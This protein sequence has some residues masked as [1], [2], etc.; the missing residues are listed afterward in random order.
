VIEATYRVRRDRIDG[1]GAVTLRHDSTLL[2]IKVGRRHAGT[3]VLLLVA[4]LDVRV[5][6]EDGELLRELTI[7]PTRSYKGLGSDEV[8]G[9]RETGVNDVGRHHISGVFSE[10]A[11]QGIQHSI[12]RAPTG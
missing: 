4:G 8:Q 10:L 9:C 12:R 11:G 7:D 2:H 3:R 6:S 1:G 5:V